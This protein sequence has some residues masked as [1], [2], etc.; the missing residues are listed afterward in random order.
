[1]ER[2]AQSNKLLTDVKPRSH[3]HQNQR[4]KRKKHKHNGKAQKL[5][6]RKQH[7]AHASAKANKT[8]LETNNPPSTGVQSTRACTLNNGDPPSTT[9][10]IVAALQQISKVDT[11][12][13]PATTCKVLYVTR[14]ALNTAT[15]HIRQLTNDKQQ[16]VEETTANSASTTKN[17]QMANE[18]GNNQEYQALLDSSPQPFTP[19]ALNHRNLSNEMDIGIPAAL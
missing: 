4:T 19:S 8:D 10:R 18:T 16:T 9:D 11:T 14:V 5:E 2:L 13:T 12:G 1:M 6:P 17:G 7:R 15:A 3:V